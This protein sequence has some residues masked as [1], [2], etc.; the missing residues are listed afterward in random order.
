MN[1]FIV[2]KIEIFLLFFYYIQKLNLSYLKFLKS[3]KLVIYLSRQLSTSKSGS[4]KWSYCISWE[5]KRERK[6]TFLQYFFI[7]ISSYYSQQIFLTFGIDRNFALFYG[8]KQNPLRGSLGWSI[9]DS[10][11]LVRLGNEHGKKHNGN[12]RT[13]E[14]RGSEKIKILERF[15]RER[16]PAGTAALDE[17]FLPLMRI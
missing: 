2:E 12:P 3:N 11:R 5:R 13:S 16:K 4:Q 8:A 14:G 6:K 9:S 1:Y 10:R 15:E 7:S 17:L